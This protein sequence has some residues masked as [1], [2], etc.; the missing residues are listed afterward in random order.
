MEG[1]V[2]RRRERGSRGAEEKGDGATVYGCVGVKQSARISE[3]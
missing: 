1:R 2:Q 3:H